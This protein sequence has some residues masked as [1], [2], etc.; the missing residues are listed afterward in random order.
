M[1]R[2]GKLDVIFSNAAIMRD[3]SVVDL[4][5]DDWDAMFAVNVKGAYLCGKYG[6]PHMIRTGGGSFIITASANSFYARRVRYC[7]LLRH[8]R[9]CHAAHSIQGPGSRAR[10]CARELHLPWLDRHAH[11]ATFSS[12]R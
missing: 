7:W 11:V 12:S 3:G 4:S 1:E 5:E 8:E 6:I 9:C 10:G 2:F